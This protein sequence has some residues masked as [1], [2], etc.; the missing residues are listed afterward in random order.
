V[1]EGEFDQAIVSPPGGRSETLTKE[2]Y[3]RQ[4]LRVRIDQLCKGQVRFFYRG[5]PV[6]SLKASRRSQ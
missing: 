2:A 5:E 6:S 1:E 3:F 4:S